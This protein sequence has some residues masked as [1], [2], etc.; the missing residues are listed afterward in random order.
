MVWLEVLLQRLVVHLELWKEQMS[1]AGLRFSLPMH[2]PARFVLPA[3]V[4]R[5]SALPVVLALQ[6]AQ[7]QSLVA[8]P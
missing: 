6:V 8:L 3:P 1:R 7:P 2:V 5:L 4:L